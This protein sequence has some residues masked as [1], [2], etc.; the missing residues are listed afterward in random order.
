MRTLACV[1]LVACLPACVVE[2]DEEHPASRVGA[3]VDD[4]LVPLADRGAPRSLDYPDG[5]L[6]IFDDNGTAFV[7]DAAAACAG[8]VELGSVPVI[9]LTTAEKV[10]NAGRTDGRQ[11]AVQARGGFVHDGVG[12]L[13]YDLQL[14]GPG[15]LDVEPLGTGLCVL[16]DRRGT[17]ERQ[18]ELLWPGSGRS[19]GDA[20]YV[21]DD[22]FA[23]VY[24][25]YHAAAFTDLCAVARVMVADAADPTAYRYDSWPDAWNPTDRDTN[26]LFEA[27]AAISAGRFAWSEHH[28]VVIADIW[29]SRIELRAGASP[30]GGFADPEPL[31]DARPPDDWFIAGGREHPALRDDGART[32][33]VSYATSTAD[34]PEL[35]LVRFRFS[36]AW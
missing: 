9:D 11:L 6:W 25:C 33:A 16:A 1:A 34:A 36:G 20:A 31:F 13:Y 32:I 23:Y 15:F 3:V 28:V 4:C 26:T 24:G 35:H 22:G 21:D 18:P 5:S 10:D 29:D 30:R 2:I 19:F 14:R 8:D 7:G 17:C 27:P 12:Y